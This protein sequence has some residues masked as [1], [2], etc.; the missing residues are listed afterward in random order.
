MTIWQWAALHSTLERMNSFA[1][2]RQESSSLAR[3]TKDTFSYLPL[4]CSHICSRISSGLCR[5]GV[6]WRCI[7]RWNKSHGCKSK[8]SMISC[9]TGVDARCFRWVGSETRVKSFLVFFFIKVSVCLISLQRASDEKEAWNNISPCFCLFYCLFK[10]LTDVWQ[11]LDIKSVHIHSPS[12]IHF[13][14]LFAPLPHFTV[15]FPVC[16]MAEHDSSFFFLNLFW[17]NACFIPSHLFKY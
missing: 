2:G 7:R 13:Q 16:F 12:H 9:S 6:C 3:S 1:R 15:T 5:Y 17:L 8:Q 11:H 14:L 4:S 10:G